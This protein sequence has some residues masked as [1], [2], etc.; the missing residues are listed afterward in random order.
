MKCESCKYAQPIPGD[1]HI[2]CRVGIP[3]SITVNEL[4][5]DDISTSNS[6]VVLDAHGVRNGWC[7]WPMN[8]DPIWVKSCTAFR[9][10]P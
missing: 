8:F 4:I 10:K 3:S 1:A 5:A 6:K 2:S 7:Y 9:E